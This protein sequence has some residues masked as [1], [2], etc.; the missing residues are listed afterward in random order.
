M[1]APTFLRQVSKGLGPK[2]ASLQ[3]SILSMAKLAEW[4]W[5]SDQANFRN[6]RCD[7]KLEALKAEAEVGKPWEMPVLEVPGT[8]LK[9]GDGIHRLFLAELVYRLPSVP[10]LIAL[11]SVHLVREA[12]ASAE[13][14]VDAS[15]IWRLRTAQPRQ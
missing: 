9:I 1:I 10:V 3:V 13:W 12:D 5:V 11:E 6:A 8:A 7:G 2:H 4:L 15:G 14:T